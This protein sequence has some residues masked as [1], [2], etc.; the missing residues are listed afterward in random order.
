MKTKI[1]QI[2]SKP[3]K[4]IISNELKEL[5][6]KLL[7]RLIDLLIGLGTCQFGSFR[8]HNFGFLRKYRDGFDIY[9]LKVSEDLKRISIDL[10]GTKKCLLQNYNHSHFT[11]RVVTLLP[12]EK[13][14]NIWCAS[15]KNN[16]DHTK[17]FMSINVDTELPIKYG[18]F[19]FWEKI[20][21]RVKED[22]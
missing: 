1:R 17:T 19:Y 18:V 14:I 8:G 11:G 22:V 20:I 10:T 16:N 12:D 4:T 15:P 2:I 6:R 13:K 5:S 9:R 3:S 7:E 21:K